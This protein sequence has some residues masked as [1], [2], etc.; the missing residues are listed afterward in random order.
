M[1]QMTLFGRNGMSDTLPRLTSCTKKK[2]D[3][4]THEPLDMS[5]TLKRIG[6]RIW[7]AFLD[8]DDAITEYYRPALNFIVDLEKKEEE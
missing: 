3:T 1:E 7:L 2:Q 8:E 5:M 6:W 4:L